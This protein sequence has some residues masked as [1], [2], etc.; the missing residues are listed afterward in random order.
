LAIP[1]A[2]GMTPPQAARLTDA[3]A[4]AVTTITLVLVVGAATGPTA[5]VLL[6]VALLATPA[7]ATVHLSVLSE[8]L[9]LALLAL[10]LAAMVDAPDRPLRAGVAAALGAMVRYAGVSLVGA[11][12]LWSCARRAPWRERVRRAMLAALPAVLLEGAWVVRTRLAS[13]GQHA[14]RH[15]ALYGDLGPT[16]REGGTTLRDWLVPETDAEWPVPHRAVIALAAAAVLVTLVVL[17]ARAARAESRRRAWRTLCACTVLLACYAMMIIVSRLVADPAI[18]FDERLLAPFLLLVTTAA[19]VGIT[20]WWRTTGSRVARAAVGIVLV[21][22]WGASARVA[23]DD[24]RYALDYGSDF[25]G[26]EWRH[27]P[28]LEWARTS[29]ASHPLYT[30]WPAAVY[31]HLHRPSYSLPTADEAEALASF[32]T[33]LRRRDGR[34]LLFDAPDADDLAAP[35]LVEQAGL[36]IVARTSDGVVLAP[37][38]GR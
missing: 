34:V 26:E 23:L 12:V 1:V 28:L 13:G 2:L 5:G 36:R 22:W 20:C 38:S 8:P 35:S 31:F 18:P 16:L 27:S 10:T 11:V 32:A 21:G 25:A 37:V 29:G 24:G 19:A 9:F 4:A 15:F 30:N 3:I 7:M 17:G 33:A 6:G 14:I